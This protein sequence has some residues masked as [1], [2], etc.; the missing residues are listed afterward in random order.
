MPEKIHVGIVSAMQRRGWVSG[1][2]MRGSESTVYEE[3]EAFKSNG[4]CSVWSARD[5][6]QRSASRCLECRRYCI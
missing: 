4:N 3:I 1:C 5:R 2:E 6:W